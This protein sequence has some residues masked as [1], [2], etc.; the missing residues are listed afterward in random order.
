MTGRFRRTLEAILKIDDTPH[1]TAL[2]FGIGLWIAFSPLLGLH[3][4]MALAIAFGFRLS[5]AAML[6]GAYTNNPWTIAPLYFAGTTLGCLILGV[7]T[8]G[9]DNIDWSARPL[10]GE[11]VS[12]FRPYLWPYVVGNTVLGALCGIAGY[13]LMRRLLERRRDPRNEFAG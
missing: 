5:R 10:Y 12:T 1:R 2:A 7:P 3:T 13:V 11:V 6:A 9:L 8:E 4:V